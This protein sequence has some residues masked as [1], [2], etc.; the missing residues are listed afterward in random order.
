ME[1]DI[2]FVFHLQVTQTFHVNVLSAVKTKADV[3][4]TASLTGSAG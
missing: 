2:L 4:N 1:K 3:Y